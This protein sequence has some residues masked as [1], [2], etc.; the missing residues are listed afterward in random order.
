MIEIIADHREKRSGLPDLLVEK[1]VEISYCTLRAGDYLVNNE[2]LIERK[3]AEDFI[4]S[5]SGNRLF[6]QCA[7]MKK[8][9]RKSLFIIE[10]NPY[11]TNHNMAES[12]IRG[13]IISIMISWQIPIIYSKDKEGSAHLLFQLARQF[14]KIKGPVWLIKRS[15]PK[16]NKDLQLRVLQGL[17]RVGPALATRLYNNFGSVKSVINADA[18]QLKMIEGIGKKSAEKI[19]A[20]V[21]NK[22]L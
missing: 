12:A 16:R 13:A 3:S 8:Q 11:R 17:P 5:I 22:V 19:V 21:E 20:F 1:N 2:L 9:N 7:Q 4:Q 18:K 6:F 10:G 15:K 14:S